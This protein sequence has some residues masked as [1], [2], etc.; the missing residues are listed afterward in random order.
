MMLDNP[1]T[2]AGTSKVSSV[3]ML[4]AQGPGLGKAKHE[5]QTRPEES[6][7]ESNAQKGLS[8]RRELK[9]VIT[10]CKHEIK[11]GKSNNG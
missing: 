6:H 7:A 3:S 4:Q 8:Q 11:N 5:D 2:Y 1:V 10:K 9:S